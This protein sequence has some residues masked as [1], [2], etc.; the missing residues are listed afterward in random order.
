V[1]AALARVWGERLSAPGALTNGEV[2][3]H[4]FIFEEPATLAPKVTRHKVDLVPPLMDRCG[5]HIFPSNRNETPPN[6]EVCISVF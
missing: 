2:H 5:V 6:L 4:D 3:S 1:K